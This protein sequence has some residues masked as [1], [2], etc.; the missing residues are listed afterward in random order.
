MT[1]SITLGGRDLVAGRRG[2]AFHHFLLQHEVHVADGVG[3]VQRMEQDRRTEVVGQVADQADLPAPSS[4]ASAVKS[5][6][7]TSPSI[8]RSVPCARAAACSGACRSRSNSI[9]VSAPWRSSSGK[10]SA[11]WPGPISTMASSGC[12]VD[13][14]HDALDHAFVVQEVLAEVFLGLATEPV[15]IA[16]EAVAHSSLVPS[17]TSRSGTHRPPRR[18]RRG[19]R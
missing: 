15:G 16:V 3:V 4:A 14:L 18:R 19:S 8:R 2:H 7:S 9:A 1:C 11:P 13:R 12:G 10:L 6:P 17:G 5:T